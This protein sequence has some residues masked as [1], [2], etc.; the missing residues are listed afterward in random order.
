MRR[1]C[2]KC[3]KLGHFAKTCSNKKVSNI[4]KSK[5]R[6][7]KSTG[8]ITKS[9]R[10]HSFVGLGSGWLVLYHGGRSGNTQHDKVWSIRVIKKGS[11]WAIV[12]RHGRRGGEKNETMRSPTSRISAFKAA[13]TLLN[14]KLRKGYVVIGK[15]K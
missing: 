1:R 4:K 8:S 13:G 3:G 14:S 9:R 10:G 6:R 5:I 2:R 11:G 15:N 7:F 12:T